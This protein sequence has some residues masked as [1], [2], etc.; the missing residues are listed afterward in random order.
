M[1]S[2]ILPLFICVALFAEAPR[3]R[4]GFE[5][6]NVRLNSSFGASGSDAKDETDGFE[7]T[8]NFV[9]TQVDSWRYDWGFRYAQTDHDWSNAPVDFN[10][11]RGASLNLSG[12]SSV[13]GVRKRY[14]VLQVN[15]DAAQQ[16]SLAKAITVQGL[17]G[18]DWKLSDEWTVGYLF[19]AETRAVSSA[20]VLIVPTFRWNFAPNW[21]FGTGRKSLVLDHKIDDAWRASLTLA[22]IQDQARL[23][24]ISGQRQE[25]ESERIA[26]L[27][28]IKHQK[29]NRVY[30]VNLGWAFSGKARRELG[31]SETKFDLAPSALLSLTSRWKF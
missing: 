15:A 21:S 9:I 14:A 30:E 5:G 26:A 25:F 16:V 1:I 11:V 24:D 12:Y 19:L 28:G 27:F 10:V 18:A 22:F 23:A 29:Q 31:G 6:L 8:G 4:P 17:Y 2:R 3:P 13:E 7:V 20:M